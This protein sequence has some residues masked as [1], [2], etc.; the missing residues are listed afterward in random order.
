MLMYKLN[1]RGPWACLSKKLSTHEK[2]SW[3]LIYVV[4]ALYDPKKSTTVSADAPTQ[5]SLTKTFQSVSITASAA[6]TAK[7]SPLFKQLNIMHF[8]KARDYKTAILIKRVIST[9]TPY[10]SSIL[11][12]PSRNTRHANNNNLNL[13]KISNV[14]GC[15]SLPFIGTKIWNSL[16]PTIKYMTQNEQSIKTY[17]MSDTYSSPSWKFALQHIIRIFP[18]YLA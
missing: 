10:H 11:S 12:F 6:R 9:N 14:Y 16:P 5:E 8:N 17:M 18:W 4:P 15:R 2:I 7:S 13:P 3:A 1:R